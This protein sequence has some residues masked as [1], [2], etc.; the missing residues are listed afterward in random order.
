MQKNL[1]ISKPTLA[2]AVIGNRRMLASMTSNGQIH[3]LWWPRLDVYQQVEEWN[4]AISIEGY[5]NLLW[6][7]DETEWD[8]TQSYLEDSPVVLTNAIHKVL[9]L[10]WELKDFVLID[11]DV[12]VRRWRIKNLSGQTVSLKLWQ[13]S[14]FAIND[15]VRYNTTK[16]LKYIDGLLHYQADTVIALFSNRRATAFQCGADAK[17]HVKACSLNCKNQD[18][19]SCGALMWDLGDVG[20]YGYVD[21]DIYLVAGNS[22]DGILETAKALKSEDISLIENDIYEHW[23]KIYENGCLRVNDEKINTLCKRSVMVFHLLSH[24]D[25]GGILAAPEVDED[26]LYCGGYGFCW[27]RDAVYVANAMDVAGYHHIARKFYSWAASAQCSDGSWAQRY[28]LDGSVAP[29]W[30]LQIDETGSILWGIWE[31]YEVTHNLEFLHEMWPSIKKGA[32][33]L[34]SYR[35]SDTGLPSDCYDIW[36][37]R[38]GQHTYSAANVYAGLISA[39]KAAK[40]MG[41]HEDA[42]RWNKIAQDI[43]RAIEKLCWE[44][45]ANHFIRSLKMD[46]GMLIK[47]F[48]IDASLLGL[49]YPF[50]VFEARDERMVSTV[51]LIEARLWSPK[52]G[53]IKRYENDAYRGGNPWI[54]T[55]LW[56]AYYY[57]LIDEDDKAKKLFD[58]AVEHATSMG[59]FPEQI[60]RNTGQPAWVVPLTWSHAMFVMVLKKLMDKGIVK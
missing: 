32:D 5:T 6:L 2:S 54:L 4:F 59:L 1:R 16:Y 35:D 19:S 30:G 33:F 43:K 45:G 36:E 27:G 58:W 25:L 56:L 34:I 22:I 17:E 31:H 55:T 29:N 7:H 48:T 24:A 11:R 3:R 38:I 46:N 10:G 41:F 37:E 12:L 40:E 51:K 26:F 8:F 44:P 57:A 21:V 42:E 14:D 50:G 53:G 18:I 9:P 20:A 60:H 15:R 28:Y 47:D 23:K 49:V 13:Y 39:A 52:I